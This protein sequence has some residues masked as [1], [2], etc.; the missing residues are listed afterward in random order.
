MFVVAYGANPRTWIWYN[1]LNRCYGNL[2]GPVESDNMYNDNKVINWRWWH[3][4][5]V[6]IV[7]LIRQTSIAE[8]NW[9]HLNRKEFDEIRHWRD[10]FIT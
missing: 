3:R 9:C 5:K 4:Q 7:E 6:L 10:W 2:V 8:S 1:R